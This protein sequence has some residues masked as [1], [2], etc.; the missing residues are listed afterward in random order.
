MKKS[1]FT[2]HYDD[3]LGVHRRVGFASD[4]VRAVL[5]WHSFVWN[6]SEVRQYWVKARMFAFDVVESG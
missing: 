4:V 1:E 2:A 6:M 3:T 5:C